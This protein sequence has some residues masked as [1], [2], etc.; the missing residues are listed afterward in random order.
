[1]VQATRLHL[2][3][4]GNFGAGGGTRGSR[5]FRWWECVAGI[6]WGMERQLSS[7][8]LPVRLAQPFRSLCCGIEKL[9]WFHNLL[10][11]FVAV[12]RKKVGIVLACVHLVE[13]SV[14]S[15]PAKIS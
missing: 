14:A 7:P 13:I 1:M 12:S 2:I 8:V 9:C 11:K 15:S 3:G 5:S 10:I 6:A 4:R